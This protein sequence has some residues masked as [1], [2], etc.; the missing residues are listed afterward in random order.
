MNKLNIKRVCIKDIE[1]DKDCFYIGRGS[2]Y[3]G[4]PQ[5][6]LANPYKIGKD[7]TREEVVQKYRRWLWNQV[8]ANTEAKETLD[9]LLADIRFR[10]E[11]GHEPLKLVCWCKE[12]EKCHGDIIINCLNWMSKESIGD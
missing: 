8:Q 7:G 5:S 6:T 12:D 2:K 10:E 9:W 1:F 3:T 11:L 4:L